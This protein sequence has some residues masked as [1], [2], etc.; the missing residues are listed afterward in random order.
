MKPSREET[1]AD[2]TLRNFLKAY[3]VRKSNPT[4]DEETSP[5]ET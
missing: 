1:Y 5:M 2:G 4:I 3:Q